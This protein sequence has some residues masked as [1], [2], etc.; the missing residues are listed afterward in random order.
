MYV[1]QVQLQASYD[2]HIQ[3]LSLTVIHSI[4]IGSSTS[5]ICNLF[6]KNALQS[7]AGLPRKSERCMLKRRM[8]ICTSSKTCVCWQLW[9]HDHSLYGLYEGKMSTGNVPLLSPTSSS[10]RKSSGCSATIIVGEFHVNRL[11]FSNANSEIS[12]NK[13]IYNYSYYNC[14]F[15][16]VRQWFAW[17]CS[18]S[19]LNNVI[20][21]MLQLYCSYVSHF[22]FWLVWGHILD[23]WDKIFLWKWFIYIYAQK[24]C[25]HI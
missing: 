18:C 1:Y 16:V 5:S 20:F 9:Q 8:Q 4:D 11:P 3:F 15:L 24:L 10:S 12:W 2:V 21:I 14:K 22:L 17:I 13:E 7:L 6:N 25:W 19:Q 23:P